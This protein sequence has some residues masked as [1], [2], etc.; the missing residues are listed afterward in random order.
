M[1]SLIRT[2][3]GTAYVDT[4]ESGAKKYIEIGCLG[5]LIEGSI[6]H[7]F[8]L[9]MAGKIGEL[10][11]PRNNGG[12][13]LIDFTFKPQEQSDMASPVKIELVNTLT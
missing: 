7:S 3:G 9:Q 10:W 6:Y 4:L 12:L 11:K 13:R 1:L 5:A 2:T 8:T